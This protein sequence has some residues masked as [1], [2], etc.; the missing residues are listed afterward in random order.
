MS[1]SER[2]LDLSDFRAVLP[3]LAYVITAIQKTVHLRKAIMTHIF[4]LSL[5]NLHS[6]YWM[7]AI[8]LGKGL[9]KRI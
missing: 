8:W 7:G 4:V 2:N 5:A 6:F 1:E 9:S 3:L